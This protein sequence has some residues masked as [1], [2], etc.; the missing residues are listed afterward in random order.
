MAKV[1]RISYTQQMTVPKIVAN[2]HANRFV[3]R[4]K[5]TFA[6]EISLSLRIQFKSSTEICLLA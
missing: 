1:A 5:F 4:H 6:N 2:I 3:N